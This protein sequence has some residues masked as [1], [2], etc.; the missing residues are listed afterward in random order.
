MLMALLSA[1]A[2]INYKN[3][4]PIDLPKL[5]IAGKNV[6][7]EIQEVCVDKDGGE[8]CPHL[9]EWLNRVILFS[10]KYTIVQK[11]YFHPI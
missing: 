11:E 6:G 2:K 4:I 1:C 10:E 5:P 3:P 9:M 8:R 7:K